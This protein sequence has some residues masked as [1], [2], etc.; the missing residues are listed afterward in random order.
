MA[1]LPVL[2]PPPDAHE[3]TPAW[4]K[5]NREFMARYFAATYALSRMQIIVIK[6]GVRQP[7]VSINLAGESATVEIVV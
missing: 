3:I 1:S 5:A 2:P 4:I 7:P 6:D